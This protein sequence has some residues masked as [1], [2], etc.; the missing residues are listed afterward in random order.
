MAIFFI[1]FFLAKCIFLL[2]PVK[3]DFSSGNWIQ[4]PLLEMRLVISQ[5]SPPIHYESNFYLST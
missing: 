2:I 3:M 4:I 1:I 5:L